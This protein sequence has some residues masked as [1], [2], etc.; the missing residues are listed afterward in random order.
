M[1]SSRQRALEVSRRLSA[2]ATGAIARATGPQQVK[3]D[4]LRVHHRPSGLPVVKR[5]ARPV[6]GGL[7]DHRMRL[8]VATM[9][10]V[11][12]AAGRAAQNRNHIATREGQLLRV[13]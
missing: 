2:K 8:E 10:P 9:A 12:L 1:S 7:S 6:I 13:A 4:L 3:N 5:P 11:A